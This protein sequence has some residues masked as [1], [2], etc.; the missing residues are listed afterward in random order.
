MRKNVY[1]EMCQ[2]VEMRASI[3]YCGFFES[4]AFVYVSIQECRFCFRY[5]SRKFDCRVVLICLLN[6]LTYFMSAN[7]LE[8]ENV[9]YETLPNEGFYRAFVFSTLA[10]MS[11]FERRLKSEVR[12]LKS[13]VWSSSSAFIT[14]KPG[15]NHTLNTLCNTAHT[16][17]INHAV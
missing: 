17:S 4:L 9:I 14:I 3:K 13:E 2:W 7:V 1:T 15:L 8:W 12:N 10:N 11:Y 6:E 5:F 16:L